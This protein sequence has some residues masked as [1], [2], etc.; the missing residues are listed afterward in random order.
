M[1]LVGFGGVE[2][3]CISEGPR[4]AP[5]VLL[6]HGYSFRGET[7]REA[8]V[9]QGLAARGFR[10]AAPDMP[11][12]RRTGCSK[13]S[14]DPLLNVEVAKSAA[15]RCLGEERPFIVGASLGGRIALHYAARVGAR[16]LFL[17]SP[18][19]KWSDPVW[20]LVGLVKVPV[21]IVRGGRDFVP[22]RIHEEL[23]RRLGAR[24]LVYED[25]G[26]AM[27]LDRPER[28]LEDLVSFL[29]GAIGTGSS[30]GK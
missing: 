24:L 20:E 25:A 29:T 14:R 11:Y 16:G 13:R 22:R 18:A 28:F 21:V 27:Y 10:V 19:L 30:K 6:L 8:G 23:A 17:A 1:E 9:L 4:G 15:A 5:G 3:P 2:C 26:H 12:G 7:W